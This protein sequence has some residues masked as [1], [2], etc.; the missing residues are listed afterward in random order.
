MTTTPTN[1]RLLP[2]LRTVGVW[3]MLDDGT[4]AIQMHLG[5]RGLRYVGRRALVQRRNGPSSEEVL[6]EV[7]H[8]YGRDDVVIYRVGRW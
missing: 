7:V 2:R 1:P 3:T 4:W 6:G 8:D 5:G